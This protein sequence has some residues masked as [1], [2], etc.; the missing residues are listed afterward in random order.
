MVLLRIDNTHIGNLNKLLY[1][2]H[3]V[4]VDQLLY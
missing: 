3:L 2:R 1:K 4:L